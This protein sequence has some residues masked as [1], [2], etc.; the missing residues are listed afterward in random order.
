MQG[1]FKIRKNTYEV[2]PFIFTFPFIPDHPIGRA[3][4][5]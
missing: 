5:E 1:W 4:C 3:E 2:I